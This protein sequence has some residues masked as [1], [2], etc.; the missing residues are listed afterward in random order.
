MADFTS[1]LYLGI[2]HGS[3]QLTGWIRLTL[4]KPAALDSLPGV[5]GV[6]RDLAALI[7]CEQALVAT[8]TLHIFLDL[9]PML[10]RPD[11]GVFVD[12]CLYPIGRWGVERT[13]ALGTPVATF[14]RHDVRALRRAIA[15]SGLKRPIVMADGFCPACGMPAPLRAYLEC[16]TARDGL[17]VIDDTQA[18]GIMGHAPGP[19]APYGSGG[20]GSMAL[21]G[22]RDR[23]VVV[24]GS[25]AKA[26]GAPIAVL[27]GSAGVIAEFTRRSATR[28]HCSPPS[29]AAIAAAA[30]ALAINR[31]RGDEL[32]AVL[33]DRVARFRR[34]LGSMAGS[35]GMFPVQHV[36]LPAPLDPV[37]LHRQLWDRGIHAVL[38]RGTDRG[39]ARVSFVLT[40]RHGD[41]E[42]DYALASL[43]E[44][45]GR[46]T[47]P[48][49]GGGSGN[50]KS[51]DE[52]RPL[53]NGPRAS[54]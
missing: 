35:P 37:L 51:T 16:V 25:L 34:G 48:D 8:S 6:E 45:T 17:V 50:G 47:H 39:P 19:P 30:H 22:I 10:S 33:G 40:A 18:L 44:L 4:G 14:P 12:D 2:D 26:F 24:V 27:A 13:A 32:R 29:A 5:A 20:G 23:R 9:V 1:A 49:W 52:L 46:T 54:R 3:R 36:R 41:D 53:W 28:V 43:A 7:G 31:C 15:N 42:I 21:A 38:S 11:V